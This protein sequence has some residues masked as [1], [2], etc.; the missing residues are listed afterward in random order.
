MLIPSIIYRLRGRSIIPKILATQPSFTQMSLL[1]S[2]SFNNPILVEKQIHECKKY[3]PQNTQLIIADNS[4]DKKARRQIAALCA[5]E[6]IIYIPLPKNHRQQPNLSHSSAL[7]WVYYNFVCTVEP[8]NFGFID[9]DIFPVEH[10]TIAD[11]LGQT[12]IYGLRQD[13]QS[14]DKKAWYLWAGFCFFR[15]AFVKTLP[16]NF[17]CIVL[18]DWQSFL[19][20]DTGGGNFSV[21]YK[22]IPP[23]SV[24]FAT[25]TLKTATRHE[26][27]DGWWHLQ[28]ASFQTSTEINQSLSHV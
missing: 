20:L 4:R 14:V 5:R 11:T 27:I 13:R 23:T 8:L 1:I 25:Q 17:S 18:S 2:I 22:N 26:K 7:N 6:Q 16:L 24:T 10:I 9:H 21:L 3:A 19:G 12:P 28:K 15:F